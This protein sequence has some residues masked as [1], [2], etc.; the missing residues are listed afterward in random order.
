MY[1]VVHITHEAVEQKGGIGT[2]LR[3]LLTARAYRKL[4]DRTILLGP[5]LASDGQ[6][7]RLGPGGRIYYSSLDGVHG[8]PHTKG[9]RAIEERHGVHLVY[10]D[11]TLV[12][13]ESG[14]VVSVEIVLVDV[15][16]SV[17][18]RVDAF[19]Y[20]LWEH[21]GLASDRCEKAKEAGEYEQYLRLAEPGYEAVRAILGDGG[22]N[23]FVSHDFMGLAT[24][25]RVAMAG[26]DSCRTVFHAHEV[27]TAR[28]LVES[29]AGHDTMFYNVLAAAMAEGRFVDE[30]FGSQDRYWKHP[31]FRQVHRCDAIFAV[32]DQ[33]VEELRFLGDEFRHRRIDCVYNGVPS[34][35]ISPEQRACSRDML[36]SFAEQLLGWRPDFVLTHVARPV[37][38][39]ALWRDLQVLLRLDPHLQRLGRRAVYFLLVSEG[40][41]V[42]D[43]E[44]V[45][46]MEGQYDWPLHHRFGRPDLI[47]AEVPLNDAIESLNLVA[48]NTRAVLVN[49]FGW[50]RKH[51]G[52]KVPEGMNFRDLR[53]GTDG[54]LGLSLYEPFGIAQ[55]EPLTYGATCVFSSVCGCRGFLE[56]VGGLEARN[57][58]VGDYTVVPDRGRS[59]EHYLG[60]SRRYRELV[61]VQ[62]A[63]RL[64]AELARRLTAEPDELQR[65]LESGYE[66]ASQMSWEVVAQ[67][68]FL[69]A[70]RR[71]VR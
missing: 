56:K 63:S 71:I 11:R 49:Q 1:R 23:I 30:V 27:A 10:G 4:V 52:S 47:G 39:K 58:L 40:S 53:L 68:Q 18:A 36:Q 28:S 13:P 8:G 62:E 12:H 43:P 20:H 55:L 57:V 26:D 66:L 3:G 61:E 9:F 34:E 21:F 46:A 15:R 17:K 60:I 38:S 7:K 70:L 19:K 2:V 48:R 14:D 69:P 31:L 33:V 5:L 6:S 50:D 24:A 37:L 59:A 25:L 44:E 64:A 29:N 54:E 16:N 65:R 45:R 22:P 51:C 35:P 32:G 42:R 67:E 41:A